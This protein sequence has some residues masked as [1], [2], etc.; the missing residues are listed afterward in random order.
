MVAG[1]I[2]EA[3]GLVSSYLKWH[4]VGYIRQSNLPVT[5]YKS[6]LGSAQSQHIFRIL[7]GIFWFMGNKT[8][9]VECCL[10]YF[11]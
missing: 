5:I 6:E 10:G 3:G 4:I 8:K 11:N 7:L 2:Q 1:G 9:K